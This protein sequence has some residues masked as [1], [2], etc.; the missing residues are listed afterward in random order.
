MLK[1][2]GDGTCYLS[3]NERYSTRSPLLTALLINGCVYWSC[4][5]LLFTDKSHEVECQ[6]FKDSQLTFDLEMRLGQWT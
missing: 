2:T 3:R 1:D 5:W 4:K 6:G